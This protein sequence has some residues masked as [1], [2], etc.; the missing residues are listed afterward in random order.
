MSAP[1]E[2]IKQL[3]FNGRRS[4]VEKRHLS[5]LSEFTNEQHLIMD[6]DGN[7]FY[8]PLLVSQ[9]L[10]IPVALVVS[11]AEWLR[12]KGYIQLGPKGRVIGL[13][14]LGQRV[15]KDRNGSQ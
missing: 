13:T 8:G 3:T 1:P 15:V 12:Q 9:T 2:I 7:V 11:A 10:G 5:V 4:N 6:Q 14:P